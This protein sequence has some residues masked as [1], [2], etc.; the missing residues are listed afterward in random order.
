MKLF[1]ITLD[2]DGTVANTYKVQGWKEMLNANCAIPFTLAEP[3]EKRIK[4]LALLSKICNIEVC[5]WLPPNAK[6]DEK[7]TSDC[8]A[9]KHEWVAKH[10]PFVSK[11]NC[12][13]YGTPKT[14]KGILIDDSATVR[15]QWKGI[16]LDAQL[17]G[18]EYEYHN[19]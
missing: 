16:A 7:F 3:M 9:V 11:I 4:R 2:L 10:L 5:T 18:Y 14:G 12:L 1:N 8:I 6:S 13:H 17:L 19:H 15:K